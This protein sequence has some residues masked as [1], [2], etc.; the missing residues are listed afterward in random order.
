M[1][2]VPAIVG[3]ARV[4][5]YTP[6]DSRHRLTGNAKQIVGGAL[7]GPASG[8]ARGARDAGELKRSGVA[9]H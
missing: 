8:L 9:C 4:V 7:L 6:I 3:G 2:P 1:R 5:C